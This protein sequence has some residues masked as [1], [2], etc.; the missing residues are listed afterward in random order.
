MEDKDKDNEIP[1][2]QDNLLSILDNLI[3][4][5][6]ENTFTA[7]ANEGILPYATPEEYKNS[8]GK[9]FRMT[10]AQKQNNMS[11]QEAFEAYIRNYSPSTEQKDNN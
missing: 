2:D 7:E 8:T 1:S 3:S 11:R 9:R 5:A 10:K 4:K 6:M